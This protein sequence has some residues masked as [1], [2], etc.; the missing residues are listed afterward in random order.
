MD[1]HGDPLPA[2]AI[3]RFGTS[4]FWA[5]RYF[6][7][8][9]ISPDGKLIVSGHDKGSLRLWDAATG[10]QLRV[11]EGKRVYANGGDALLAA[12]FSPDG[13]LLATRSGGAIFRDNSIRIWD[14][15]TWRQ[16]RSFGGFKLN[17]NRGSYSG[18]DYIPFFELAFTPDAKALLTGPGDNEDKTHFLKLFDVQTGKLLRQFKGHQAKVTCFTI[19]PDGQTVATGSADKMV[20][21]WDL[22]TGKELHQFKDHKDEIRAI[23]FSPNSKLVA[24]S[25]G[26]KDNTIRLWDVAAGKFVRK[27]TRFFGNRCATALVFMPDGKT[28]LAGDGQGA[29]TFWNVEKGSVRQ[30][31]RIKI[32][33]S[34]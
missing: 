33:N 6:M 19:A 16:I 5:E 22:T 20:R 10:K 30:G 29:V 8:A 1:R 25:G 11:L 4:R 12:V 23:A 27:L 2:G 24:S 21:L 14:T 3:Q 31:K 17:R 7:T 13:K 15:I 26:D 34:L 9:A 28:L 18:N 32:R